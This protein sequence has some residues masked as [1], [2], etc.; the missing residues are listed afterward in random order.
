MV[1]RR[2]S[3]ALFLHSVRFVPSGNGTSPSENGTETGN[4]EVACIAEDIGGPGRLQGGSAI[5]HDIG[6]QIIGGQKGVQ[7]A[8][9]NIDGCGNMTFAEFSPGTDVHKIILILIL[10]DQLLQGLIETEIDFIL[11]LLPYSEVKKNCCQA[12]N[13]N[14]RRQIEYP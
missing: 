5:D 1:T 6:K 12:E 14:A 7:I 9:G 4:V 10:A 13:E 3:D 2:Q 8:V 11:T